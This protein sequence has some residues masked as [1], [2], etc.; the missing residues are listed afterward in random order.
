MENIRDVKMID[1]KLTKYLFTSP[2]KR[3]FSKELPETFIGGTRV[4][5]GLPKIRKP[6]INTFKQT[7]NASVSMTTKKEQDM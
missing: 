1:G 5:G 2:D 3:G 6:K 7:R 4:E